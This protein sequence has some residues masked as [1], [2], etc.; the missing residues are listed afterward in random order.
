MKRAN[1]SLTSS[2]SSA[3]FTNCHE[4]Q[5]REAL[6]ALELDD[7]FDGVFGAGAMGA[8]CKPEREAF[9]KFFASFAIADASRCVFFEDS[10]KNLRAA[11]SF[12][13]RT[14]LLA[15]ATLDEELAHG[16]DSSLDDALACVDV[17]VRARELSTLAL[18][19]SSVADARLARALNVVRH[20]SSVRALQHEL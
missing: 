16:T 7:L 14:V 5:A 10:L 17:V 13:M 18:A 20:P 19:R 1:V 11:K 9:E 15:S 4:K 2:R 8:T 12:G 3:V 6:A